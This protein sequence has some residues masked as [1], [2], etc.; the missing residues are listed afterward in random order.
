MVDL[1]ELPKDVPLALYFILRSIVPASIRN[2]SAAFFLTISPDIPYDL[3]NRIREKHYWSVMS[4]GFTIG[5]LFCFVTTAGFC[6]FESVLFP[7]QCEQPTPIEACANVQYFYND[8]VNIIMYTLITPATVSIGLA[9]LLATIGTWRNMDDVLERERSTLVNL[10]GLIVVTLII[11]ASSVF[12]SMYINDVVNTDSVVGKKANE[13]HFWFLGNPTVENTLQPITVYYTILNFLI[14][15]FTLS[16]VAVFVTAIRPILKL[17][18]LISC[19][20][21]QL[22]ETSEV[23]IERMARFAD[24][25][26]FAKLLLAIT[27]VHSFVWSYS[28][29]AVTQ[30]FNIERGFIV[31]VSIFFIAIPRL[32]FELEWFR[33]AIRHN[34]SGGNIELTPN[35]IRGFHYYTIWIADYVIIGGYIISVL[36]FPSFGPFA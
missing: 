35:Y 6:Y 33:A 31:F 4:Y 25:Y 30:N 8:Y 11:V 32:H 1:K 14:L 18:S 10:K 5:F 16:C 24:V 36:G 22:V 34:K 9:L 27:M 28:P 12:I 7:W 23:V 20:K 19:D 2:F 13:L 21:F 26:L 17:S 15:V 29:L 3:S